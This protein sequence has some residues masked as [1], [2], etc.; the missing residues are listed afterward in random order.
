MSVLFQKFI[1]RED[2][3]AN[4]DVI[5]VFGDNTEREGLGGQ[6]GEMRGEPNSIG[7]ATKW[8]PT[9]GTNAYF[10]DEEF[11]TVIEIIKNDF[12]LVEKAIREGRTV[13]IPLDGLGT[14]LSKLPEMAPKVDKWLKDYIVH[15]AEIDIDEEWGI[16][17]SPSN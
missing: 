6:A 16:A 1:Y 10:S 3:K 7:V 15:L 17:A 4:P 8:T 2:L 14:G 11:D 5:Y 12:E 13:V 9:S